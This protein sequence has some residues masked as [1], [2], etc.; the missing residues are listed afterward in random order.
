M[1]MKRAINIRNEHEQLTRMV[2][3]RIETRLVEPTACNRPPLW[4]ASCPSWPSIGPVRF[5]ADDDGGNAVYRAA[6]RAILDWERENT[7]D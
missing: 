5:R 1:S 3:V 2:G 7:Y 4:E 6:V